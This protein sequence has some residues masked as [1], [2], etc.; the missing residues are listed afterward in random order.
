MMQEKY[1]LRIHFLVKIP[2]KLY[3][4]CNNCFVMNRT[5]VVC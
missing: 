2:A 5:P 3:L 4:Q 1:A